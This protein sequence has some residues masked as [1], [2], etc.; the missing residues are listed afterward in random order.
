[1]TCS[2]DDSYLEEQPKSKTVNKIKEKSEDLIG[3]KKISRNRWSSEEERNIRKYFA[4]YIRTESYPSL[5][6]IREI[7]QK[8]NILA[9]RNPDVIK[10]KLSNIYRLNIAK[11]NKNANSKKSNSLEQKTHQPVKYKSASINNSKINKSELNKNSKKMKKST[12]RLKIK[13]HIKYIFN[14]Y[15][16]K[17]R[18]P[19]AQTCNEAKKHDQVLKNLEVEYIQSI[20]KEL[21]RNE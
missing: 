14:S 16:N 3:R 13:Q 18:V 20:F 15:I 17:R 7:K 5:S 2:L 19:S 12:D 1:M 10:T 21:C 4:E 9:K 6:V 11:A 8:Y